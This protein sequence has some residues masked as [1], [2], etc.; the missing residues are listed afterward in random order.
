VIPVLNYGCPSGR[1]FAR[2]EG[3]AEVWLICDLTR[4]VSSL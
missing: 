2:V 1:R 3:R 4:E